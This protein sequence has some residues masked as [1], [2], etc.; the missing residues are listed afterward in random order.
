MYRLALLLVT[1]V[2]HEVWPSHLPRGATR[3][4]IVRRTGGDSLEVVVV[5]LP[6]ERGPL[7][8]S[9]PATVVKV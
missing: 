6:L 4:T 5:E 2:D 3:D 9:E 1:V 7:L 8:L